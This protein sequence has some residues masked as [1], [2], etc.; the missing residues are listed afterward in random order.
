[1]V[2]ISNLAF[3][4]FSANQGADVCFSEE[5]VAAKLMKARREVVTYDIPRK[6]VVG[7]SLSEVSLE[8]LN[9]LV[10]VDV[11]EF[12]LSLFRKDESVLMVQKTLFR[13]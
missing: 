1:M 8:D 3:R 10:P 13:L 4:I 6:L 12:G 11:V 9:D 5:I 7:S 2:R